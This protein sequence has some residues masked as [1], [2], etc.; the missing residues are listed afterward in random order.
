MESE[1]HPSVAIGK[2]RYGLGSVY[3]W[4]PFFPREKE[5]NNQTRKCAHRDDTRSIDV[6]GVGKSWKSLCAHPP[7]SISAWWWW[8]VENECE[9][10]RWENSGKQISW[11]QGVAFFPGKFKCSQ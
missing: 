11:S 8:V 1:L 9:R 10:A 7:E 6:V 3:Q 2:S 5:H 4:Q